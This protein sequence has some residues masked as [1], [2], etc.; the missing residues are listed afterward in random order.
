MAP[1]NK[2]QKKKNAPERPQPQWLHPPDEENLALNP[3][4]RSEEQIKRDKGEWDQAVNVLQ[5]KSVTAPL[6]APPPGLLLTLVGSFLTS[7]GFNSASRRYT[8][9]LAS[10]KKL[11]AWQFQLGTKIPKGFPDLVKIYKEWYEDY[12]ESVQEDASSSE[13]DDRDVNEDGEKLEV[14]QE[15]YSVE[16]KAAVVPEETSSSGT[17][18]DSSD[19]GESD[20]KPKSPSPAM[21]PPQKIRKGKRPASPASSSSTSSSDS[22]ADDENEVTTKPPT[23]DPSS[24]ETSSSSESDAPPPKFAKADKKAGKTTALKTIPQTTRKAAEI[25]SKKVDGIFPLS[26]PA[27]LSVKSTSSSATLVTDSQQAPNKASTS[28]STST[29]SESSSSSASS[30]PSPAKPASSKRKRSAS[31]P[32]PEPV[33]EAQQS[34]KQKTHFQ[35]VP[36]DTKVDVKLASNAY[37]AHEYGERAHQD[38]S[39]T[40]G[41]EFTKEKNKKK[42]G[43]YRG[44]AIDVSG[45]KGIKFED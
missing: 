17:S 9:Q 41:K 6:K 34:K 19:E 24:D 44:G 14:K 29:S 25:F 20:V 38:L 26:K 28:T 2:K 33:V 21:N 10:R 43:S 5:H 45:G 30:E 15:R 22:D 11:D 39:V 13:D 42:R 23:T 1:V 12:Q 36:K 8:T 18:D 40:R 27:D 4:P 7:Y 16:N 3:K 31:P 32:A 37:V 35:R